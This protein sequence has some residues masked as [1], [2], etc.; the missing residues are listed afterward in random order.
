MTWR[1]RC[2]GRRPSVSSSRL[3]IAM[4]LDL[5]LIESSSEKQ[6]K[7]Q[8]KIAMQT[9]KECKGAASRVALVMCKSGRS[10]SSR[11]SK[12]IG[13]SLRV[14][15]GETYAKESVLHAKGAKGRPL[16]QEES[17]TH[18]LFLSPTSCHPHDPIPLHFRCC[19]H[20]FFLHCRTSA[21]HGRSITGMCLWLRSN[22][23]KERN[24]QTTQ[25]NQQNKQHPHTSQG[26]GQA[27]HSGKFAN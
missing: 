11:R 6:Q 27:K 19:L 13:T 20:F 21:R 26:T 25:Q 18:G 10:S 7:L 15:I 1:L 24:H 9:S 2:P 5:K 3:S 8:T 23:P 12:S 16:I 14:H 22:F 4:W 17:G